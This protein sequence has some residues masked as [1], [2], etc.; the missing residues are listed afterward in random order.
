MTYLLVKHKLIQ[1][2]AWK[3]WKQTFDTHTN[4]NY[5]QEKKDR[6]FNAP[7]ELV[8]PHYFGLYLNL[9]LKL[10]NYADKIELFGH[11]AFEMET[12]KNSVGAVN[13]KTIC[14]LSENQAIF[15]GTLS[16]NTEKAVKYKAVLT[17]AFSN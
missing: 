9:L 7:I 4:T 10:C 3:L 1:A 11:L 12:V 14:Y 15:L 5:I 8:T 13:E 17:Q 16:K 2:Y 6:V